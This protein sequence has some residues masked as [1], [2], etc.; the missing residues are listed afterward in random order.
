MNQVFK[1]LAIASAALTLVAQ[2]GNAIPIPA[3]TTIGLTGS[4]IFNSSSVDTATAVTGW[5]DTQVQSGKG[6]FAPSLIPINTPVTFTAPWS[7]NTSTPI[8]AFW[9]VDG[10]T[11][12]LLTSYVTKQGSGSVSINGYGEISGNGYSDTFYSWSFTS[13]DPSS[14]SLNGQDTWTFSASSAPTPD[15]G[16]TI[17]LLG[18]ALS[19]IALIKRKLAA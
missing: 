4:A 2:V 6:L 7:F 11:F 15:G 17:M 1:K 13:Q 12:E 14:G 8:S 18:A 9:A 3:N 5:T 16:T 10:Y 19:G